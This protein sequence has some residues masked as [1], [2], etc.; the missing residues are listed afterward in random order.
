MVDFLKEVLEAALDELVGFG[1]EE[2]GGVAGVSKLY[3]KNVLNPNNNLPYPYNN[4]SS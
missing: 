1:L 2:G 3:F 4:N